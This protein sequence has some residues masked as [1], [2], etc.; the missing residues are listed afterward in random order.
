MRLYYAPGRSS[1]APH[2]LLEEIGKAYDVYEV[3]IPGNEQHSPE[4]KKIN[5]KSKV[6]ALLRDDGSVLTEFPAIALWL[7]FTNPDS[8]ILPEDPESRA[9]TVELLE[10]IGSNVHAQGFTRIRRPG[11]FSPSETDHDQVRAR[12]KEIFNAGLQDLD[13]L[14][15]GRGYVMGEF[16]IA[17]TGIFYIERWSLIELKQSLP[18]NLERHYQLMKSRPAV[19]RVLL[20]EGLTG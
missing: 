10:F 8:G 20:K 17:D 7:A 16:S 6:P 19:Q 12:G 18:P 2:I 13:S 15:Q 4:F 9:R 1:I 5:P 11:N 3:D 14:M